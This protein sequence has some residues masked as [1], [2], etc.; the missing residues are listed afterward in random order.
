[1]IFIQMVEK[2]RKD[3]RW[4]PIVGHGG[5]V[6]AIRELNISILIQLD[7]QTQ[8]TIS[9]QENVEAGKIGTKKTNVEAIAS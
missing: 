5:G 6:A 2:N 7:V 8:K 1:M 3:A 9:F 4:V